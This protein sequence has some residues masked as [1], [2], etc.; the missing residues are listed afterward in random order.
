MIKIDEIR[1][2]A[3]KGNFIVRKADDFIMGEGICLGDAD[4]I[5]NYKEE[6]YTEESYKEFYASIGV[7]IEK[8]KE[9]KKDRKSRDL[10][11]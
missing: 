2:Q 4:S 8:E 11:F 3:E 1:Y 7:D 10:N 5:D 9:S 6:P